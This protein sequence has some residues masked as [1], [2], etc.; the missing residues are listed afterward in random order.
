MYIPYITDRSR[1]WSRVFGTLAF[2]TCVLVVVNMYLFV[3]NLRLQREVGERQQFIT[4]T[5]QIQGIAKEIVTALADAA[6]KNN[7]EQLKQL[8]T[9]HGII[10]FPVNPPS[11][12]EGQAK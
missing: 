2:I 4:D 11:A 8:L 6:T 7:D 10:T 12:T 5:A 9:S 3:G 1:F